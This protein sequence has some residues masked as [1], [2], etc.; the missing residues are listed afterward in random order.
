MRFGRAS[1]SKSISRAIAAVLPD[2]VE[3]LGDEAEVG[4][5]LPRV[6]GLGH[7]TSSLRGGCCG[8][9]GLEPG[10]LSLTGERK[11]KSII[12]LD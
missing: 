6:A 1:A 8:P 4:D 11:M 7:S 12:Q 3:L 2:E 9:A 10:C 5:L